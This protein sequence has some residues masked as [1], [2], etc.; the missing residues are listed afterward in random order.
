MFLFSD[1][2]IILQLAGKSLIIFLF[3]F[4]ILLFI[5]DILFIVSLFGEV[6]IYLYHIYYRYILLFQKKLK[7]VSLYK[8]KRYYAIL[9]QKKINK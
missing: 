6:A 4:L 1:L 2:L 7:S 9:K 3:L 5:L 8:T